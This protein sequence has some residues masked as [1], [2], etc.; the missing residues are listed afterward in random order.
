MKNYTKAQLS[1]IF[2][3][4]EKTLSKQSTLNTI[5]FKNSLGV[6]KNI[7]S[8]KWET[9][10]F[11]EC[12]V[13][14]TFYSGFKAKT[15]SDKIPAI[16]NIFNDY[17][18][19]AKFNQEKIDRIIE[20]RKV[21]SNRLKIQSIVY[22]A[23]QIIVLEKEY[24]SFNHY[25]YS[26]GDLSKEDALYS[27]IKDLK[28]RFKYLGKITVFHFLTDIGLN[29]LKPDRVLSR[30]CYRLGL[31]DN[32]YDFTG[33]IEAGRKIA[34]ATKEPIRYIDIILVLYGQV[35]EKKEFG[36]KEGICLGNK[37]KCELC[38]IY[39]YCIYK[40]KKKLK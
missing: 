21:I 3:A 12:L 35:D 39:K 17:K 18:K 6:F 26:F 28:K 13:N 24:G 7:N 5:E 33:V 32:E 9:N 2:R 23:N 36:L 8:K 11:F 19:V 15:V 22:N 4:A 38:G 20:S 10:K 29:V 25:L 34:E 16:K 1:S 31:V 40:G 37:P 14:V 27:L 30:I